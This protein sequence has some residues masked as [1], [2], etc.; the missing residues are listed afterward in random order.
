M[1]FQIVHHCSY[2]HMLHLAAVESC[3][4]LGMWFCHI[5]DVYMSTVDEN[6][7][8]WFGGGAEK[9]ELVKLNFIAFFEAQAG[10]CAV[11]CHE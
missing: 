2:I 6:L 11:W 3:T 1:L 9:G 7:E 4:S 10:F 8:R 5:E